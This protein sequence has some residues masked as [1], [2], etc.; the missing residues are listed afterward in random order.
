MWP[1]HRHMPFATQVIQLD[2]LHEAYDYASIA[3]SYTSRYFFLWFSFS[4]ACCLDHSLPECEDFPTWRAHV[5]TGSCVHHLNFIVTGDF[6]HGVLSFHLWYL[7]VSNPKTQPLQWF[8]HFWY[9]WLNPCGACCRCGPLPADTL[10]VLDLDASKIPSVRFSCSCV[11]ANEF[12]TG[13]LLVPRCES[14]VVHRG[15][16]R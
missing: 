7:L 13:F 10:K 5:D 4:H 2:T 6:L 8:H 11:G 3:W 14:L 16:A 12:M 9:S 1:M 15:M